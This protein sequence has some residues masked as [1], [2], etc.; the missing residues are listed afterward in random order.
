MASDRDQW[1]D[2][3]SGDS[4]GWLT[5]FLAEED[6]FDRRSLWRLGS[7]GVG[8][9]AAVIVALLANH[10]SVGWRR[11]QTASADLARQSQQIQWVAKESQ[12]ETRRLASAVDTLNSDR[13]RLYARVT[14]L[15][16]GLDSITGSIVRQ[17]TA[18][19]PAATPSTPSASSPTTAASGA[20]TPSA[21]QPA[22]DPTTASLIGPPAPATA[23]PTTVSQGSPAP[24]AS[25]TTTATPDKST[26]DKPGTDKP[27]TVVARQP[28]P[29]AAASVLS[30]PAPT[31]PVARQETTNNASASA[32]TAPGVTPTAP[33]MPAK[34]FMAPPD[35]AA[36]TLTAPE[37]S[38]NA[39]ALPPLPPPQTIAAV[40]GMTEP[41]AAE[42][43]APAA[44]AVQ[45]TEFGVDLGGANS[46]DGL[47]A[48]WRGLLKYRS[49]KALAEL[50][51]I[52][53]V[54]ERSNG[55]GMQLRLVA[56]PIS[57]AAAAAR[58]CA[59]LTESDRSCEP[60]VFD[61]QRLAINGYNSTPTPAPAAISNGHPATASTRSSRKRAGSKG[62]KTEEPAAKPEPS[63]PS[64]TS[65]LGLR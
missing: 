28:D 50:R 21:P 27:S 12:N 11:E 47:R 58:I 7:W 24:A 44:I 45:R 37:P 31:P 54:K 6:E 30:P 14:V 8:S 33:L 52:I 57:D 62:A 40:P 55:L 23:A 19:S 46:I 15:E 25:A 56:G 63:K 41:D 13:D 32:I 59:T 53:V 9:V 38:A 1:A 2:N 20:A 16:Q 22:A 48:L 36:A 3:L 5:G 17:S 29:A 26:T 43:H 51:P 65:F 39:N 64:L 60:S 42:T 49:N 34:S 18:A 4:G 10:S 61:G 35:P